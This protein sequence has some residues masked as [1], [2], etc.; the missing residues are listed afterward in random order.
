VPKRTLEELRA[1]IA[2]LRAERPGPIKHAQRLPFAITDGIIVAAGDAH[3]WPGEASAAHRA[4][5][6]MCTELKPAALVLMGDIIDGARISRWPRGA[7]EDAAARPTPAQELAVSQE[8][9]REIYNATR[10]AEHFWVLGNH[11]ARFETY[12]N[13]HAPEFV[14]VGGTRLKDHFP[15]WRPCWSVRVNDEA[16]TPVA[17]K[18]RW[19]GGIHAAHNNTVNSGMSFVTGHLHSLKVSPFSDYRGTRYGVDSGTLAVPHGPQFEHY[20]EDNPVN[21]RS[22]FVVLTFAGGRLLPPEVAQVIDEAAGL[23]C[24]R[25][26]LLEV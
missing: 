4:L 17:L 12:L 2:R 10:D 6:R 13:E 11:D 7:W 5:V 14:G 9:L 15:D 26:K 8:R 20:T 22:G 3:Y 25:G 16:D 21:W 24:F 1:E 23:V 18:H 19:K